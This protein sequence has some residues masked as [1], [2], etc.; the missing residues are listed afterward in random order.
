MAFIGLKHPVFAPITEYTDGTMPTYGAGM[1]VG[2]AMTADVSMSRRDQRLDADD[3]LSEYDN[4]VNGGTITL[5]VADVDDEVA[6]AMLGDVA[7][8]DGEYIQTDAM[9]PYVG[10][11]YVRTRVKKGVKSFIAYWFP[12]TMWARGDENAQTKS[13]DGGFQTPSLNGTVI[14]VHVVA[15]DATHFVARKKFDNEAAAIAWLD[16]KAKIGA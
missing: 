5:G 6:V 13:P 2:K 7:G 4:S 15:E 8:E 16:G 10:F 14:G 1:I 9:A 12:R 3:E 11:G